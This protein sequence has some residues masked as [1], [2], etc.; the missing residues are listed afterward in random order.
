MERRG[1]II[2]IIIVIV[3]IIGTGVWYF[4]SGK[5]TEKP[6]I[7]MPANMIK[8][9]AFFN[10]VSQNQ[11]AIVGF[12]K[13]NEIGCY[14]YCKYTNPRNGFCDIWSQY[15]KGNLKGFPRGNSS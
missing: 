5:Q 14:Y 10:S 2:A 3:L 11:G 13:D 9:V 6:S 12:C 1:W 4:Y 8:V 15:L 7:P